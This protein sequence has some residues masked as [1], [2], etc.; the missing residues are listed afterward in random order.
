MSSTCFEEIVCNGAGS[1][2]VSSEAAVWEGTSLSWNVGVSPNV[3]VESNIG[4][5]GSGWTKRMDSS[6]L[7]I[8]G[9][10]RLGSG[11]VPFC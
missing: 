11:I 4:D 2:R 8:G 9:G 5:T 10:G 3:G 7:E 1:S 6:V